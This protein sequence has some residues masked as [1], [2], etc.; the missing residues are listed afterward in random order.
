MA[1]STGR[2]Q[3]IQT[4]ARHQAKQQQL[5]TTINENLTFSGTASGAMNNPIDISTTTD[6]VLFVSRFASDGRLSTQGNFQNYL[7]PSTFA[8]YPLV[9]VLTA[10]FVP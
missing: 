1:H 6:A 10:S 7:D 4:E 2:Y 3:Y 8:R 5:S 9:H